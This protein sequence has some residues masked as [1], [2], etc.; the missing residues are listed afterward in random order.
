M[1]EFQFDLLSS[2]DE[3]Q[4][5]AKEHDERQSNE[6]PRSPLQYRLADEAPM[7]TTGELEILQLVLSG[8]SI[9]DI[10]GIIYRSS[11]GVKW[12]L[13]NIYHKFGVGDR[14]ALIKLAAK[15]G[16]QFRTES[17]IKHSFCLQIGVNENGNRNIVSI[18]ESSNNEQQARNLG[19]TSDDSKA[20]N[21][22]RKKD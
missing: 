3:N 15:N 12:R 13:S 5:R 10:M 9:T 7:L 11:H 8:A 17:G 4:K 1:K 21:G 16:I 22:N 2:P 18:A 19:H 6:L 20:Q 14:L